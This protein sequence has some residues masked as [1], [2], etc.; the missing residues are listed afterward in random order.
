[1]PRPPPMPPALARRSCCCPS[2]ATRSRWPDLAT[3]RSG[4][5]CSGSCD[6]L[7]GGPF[8]FVSNLEAVRRVAADRG[9]ARRDGRRL[10]PCTR[11]G[12]ACSAGDID[13][14]LVYRLGQVLAVATRRRSGR[15]S[16]TPTTSRRSAPT[17]YRWPAC[18][19]GRCSTRGKATERDFAEVAARSAGA[20]RAGNPHARA[21]GRLPVEQAARGRLR[22]RAAARARRRPDLRRRRRGRPRPRRPGPPSCAEHPAWIRG[23]DHRI[24][25]HLPGFRD[26]TSSPS[27]ALAA[28][29][30]GYRRRA[31]R[32]RRTLRAPSRRQE[33]ILRDALG[34]ARRHRSTRRAA[35][36]G[37]PGHGHR[38]HPHHR[39]RGPDH[40][41]LC[42][43][44]ARARGRRPAAAAEPG[45]PARW[46]V[47]WPDRRRAMR[48]LRRHRRRPDQA[49]SG[50][51]DDVSIAGLVREAAARALEDA[52]LTWRT[53]TPSSSA[54]RPT[55]SRASCSPSSSWPTPSARSASRC[56]AFTPRAR[57]AGRPPSSASHL[58]RSRAI[59]ERVLAVAWEKQS[60]GNAQWGLSGARS[61]GTGAGGYFAPWIRAYIAERRAPEHIGWLVAVKDRLNALKNPYAHLQLADITVEKVKSSPMLW[62]PVRFLESCPSSDGACRG[63]PDQRR[64]RTARRKPPAWVAATVGPQ[65]A[66]PRSPAVIRCFRRPGSTAPATSTGRPALPRP[67][68]RSTSPNSTCRSAGSSRCGLRCHGIA[69]EG[70][71][72]QMVEDGTTELARGV[73]RQPVGR[74]A[75]DQP[76]RRLGDAPLRRGRDAGAGHARAS[77]RSTARASPSAQAYG[78]SA[79]YFATVVLRA[80]MP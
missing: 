64:R 28:R 16:S 54:R 20:T 41:R 13:T 30:A 56:C 2:S 53:S 48:T 42:R 62:D 71:G 66:R 26:L 60:E 36:G 68:A 63:R 76:D 14:A 4:F 22:P 45:L 77:T 8:A 55:P 29:K 12:S 51:G 52:E 33:L 70:L 27:T 75:L 65:R 17:R 15:C 24:E 10:R 43:P 11:H 40:G 31:G 74:R 78:G 35:P 44:R 50:Q 49:T 1:M 57:S 7:T 32:R 79:Q 67:A 80:D 39:G 34:L 25:P 19:R 23:I 72:W 46:P 69:A 73:P 18:R 61:R 38:A 58:I 59:H 5:T 21:R 6:Y 9:V 3:A 47:R 37:Q